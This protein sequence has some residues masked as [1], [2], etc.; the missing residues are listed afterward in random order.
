MLLT[1][2]RCCSK[3]SLKS[4]NAGV[5]VPCKCF[6][7]KRVKAGIPPVTKATV[8]LPSLKVDGTIKLLSSGSVILLQRQGAADDI[9]RFI[10]V[11]S[12]AATT[13]NASLIYEIL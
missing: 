5:K 1:I 2:S 13:K 10:S 11:L 8:I 9:S 7:N 3:K 12:V 4:A 6:F